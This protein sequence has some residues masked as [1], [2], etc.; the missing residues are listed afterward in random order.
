[1]YFNKLQKLELELPSIEEQKLIAG[2]ANAIEQK[3]D[4]IKSSMENEM[5]EILSNEE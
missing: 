2:F 1:M 5:N 3:I 4:L